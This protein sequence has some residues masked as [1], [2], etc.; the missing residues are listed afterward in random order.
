M[1]DLQPLDLFFSL[2]KIDAQPPAQMPGDVAV[3]R[4]DARVRGLGLHDDVGAGR[5]Q[6][7]VAPLRV[8]G[9]RDRVAVPLPETLGED[10]HVVAVQVHGVRGRGAVV[11]DEPVGGG[12]GGEVVDVPFGGGWV[13]GVAGVGEEEDGVVVVAA[14]GDAVGLP[15]PLL[16]RVLYDVDGDGEGDVR[17]GDGDGVFRHGER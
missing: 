16:G 1:R 4:P 8:R 12:V 2:D 14:E 13:G 6:R 11:G 3:V 17:G 10:E 7:D 15:V 9:P 5:E